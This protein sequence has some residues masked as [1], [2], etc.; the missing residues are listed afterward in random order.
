MSIE[1]R[2]YTSSKTGKIHTSYRA[3]VWSPA[4]GRKIHGRFHK[5]E[6]AARQD[7]TDIQ[8]AIDSGAVKPSKTKKSPCQKFLKNGVHRQNLLCLQT[9]PGTSIPDF[10]AIISLTFLA[11]EPYAKYRPYTSRNMSTLWPKNTRRR[12]SINVC[13]FYRI[14]FP[15]P[16]MCCT[17]SIATRPRVSG[18]ARS[19]RNQKSSGQMS[20]SC[21]FYLS[22]K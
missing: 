7:E 16:S 22:P 8:R 5:T 11:Q 3:C 14:S 6:K 15:L 1:K 21:I 17:A 10:I 2:T 20:R 18:A 19:L 4:E 13:P 9:A 12:R